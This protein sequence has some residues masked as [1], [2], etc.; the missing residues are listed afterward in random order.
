LGDEITQASRMSQ[1]ESQLQI[2]RYFSIINVRILSSHILL[3][4]RNIEVNIYLAQPA[5]M[6]RI[7]AFFDPGAKSRAKIQ[8][9]TKVFFDPLATTRAKIR[10]IL[11]GLPVGSAHPFS[12][13]SVL[14]HRTAN[15]IEE[16]DI[17][18]Y[19]EEFF[20]NAI[21]LGELGETLQRRMA[22]FHSHL[23]M[24][25]H[26][27]SFGSKSVSLTH[28]YSALFNEYVVFLQFLKELQLTSTFV[29]Q[30]QHLIRVAGRLGI[31]FLV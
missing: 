29:W 18:T 12:P 8:D 22:G 20:F 11:E 19:P 7:K 25:T 26:N 14:L 21:D 6:D 16:I 30:T 23:G 13:D 28:L 31:P 4:P 24:H 9:I 15:G 1:A 27:V 10:G 3:F 5:A 2:S 17:S